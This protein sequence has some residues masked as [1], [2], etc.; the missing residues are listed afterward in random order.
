MKI[1]INQEL[2]TLCGL[3]ESSCLFGA[4]KIERSVVILED[5]CVLCGECERVCPKKA[6]KITTIE[7]I[8][9]KKN[10]SNNEGI[11]IFIEHDDH[12]IRPVSFEILS[13]GRR[14]ADRLNQKLV[15]VIISQDASR[16]IDEIIP[17]GI[18]SLYIAEHEDLEHYRTEVYT[19]ILSNIISKFKPNILLFGATYL[20]RDLAP[21][22]AVRLHTG[23]TADCTELDI[24]EQ[25]NLLQIRPTYGGSIMA[26][27]ICPYHRPQMATVR[28][29]TMLKRKVGRQENLHIGRIPVTLSPS[30]TFTNII[31]EI[32]EAKDFQSV[33]EADIVV[34]GGRGVGSSENFK[35][36]EELAKLLGGSVGASRAAVDEGWKPH[37]QQVGQ[38][39]KTISPKVY[40]GCGVSGAIQHLIGMR[41]SKKI[42]AINKDKNAPIMKIADI[43]IV[44]DLHEIVP[45]L[46]EYI[47]KNKNN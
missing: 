22:L 44:G 31:R 47:R 33:E 42:I 25:G 27:I 10:L 40:I 29:N 34:V 46:T 7:N 38:T 12:T 3:C 1:F 45:Q 36:L 16:F 39:G 15:A 2:C 43:A 13:E 35:I 41:T 32:E 24:D 8:E 14:L 21:R 4:I 5:K 23:L 28:P 30:E 19:N 18:D 17:Y 6:I 11:W 37:Q 9:R 26:S 20:G